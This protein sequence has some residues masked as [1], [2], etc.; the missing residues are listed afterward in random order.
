MRFLPLLVLSVCAV[1]ASAQN[2][3]GYFQGRYDRFAAAFAAKNIKPFDEAMSPDFT[4]RGPHGVILK[5]DQV[6]TDFQRQMLSMS[7]V[8][9][10]RKVASVNSDAH[11]ATLIV[12]SEMDGMMHDE[13]GKFHKFHF[14]STT[15]DRWQKAKADWRLKSSEL[16]KS[17]VTIDGKVVPT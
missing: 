7:K 10:I 11:G 12:N 9:W 8:H 17:H 5:R 1:H 3:Q 2:L 4:A 16:T 13:S 14:T 15:K 6:K